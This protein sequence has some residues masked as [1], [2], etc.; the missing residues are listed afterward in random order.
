MFIGDD[1]KTVVETSCRKRF[2]P[3]FFCSEL[4]MLSPESPAVPGIPPK[5]ASSPLKKWRVPCPRLREHVNSRENMP[6][7]SVGMAPALN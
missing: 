5:G 6:T 3:S 1:A 7:T 4:S 2:P